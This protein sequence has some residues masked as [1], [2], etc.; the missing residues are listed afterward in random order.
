MERRRELPCIRRSRS[1]YKRGVVR[2]ALLMS[3]KRKK[4]RNKQR[5]GKEKVKKKT[6]TYSVAAE[7]EFATKIDNCYGNGKLL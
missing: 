5:R 1:L 2:S 3:V 4:V 6:D 7:F